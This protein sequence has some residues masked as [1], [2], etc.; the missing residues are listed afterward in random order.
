MRLQWIAVTAMAALLAGC[1]SVQQPVKQTPPPGLAK[2]ILGAVPAYEPL[3][4]VRI[5][6]TSVMVSSIRL[7]VIRKTSVS[8]AMPGFM[9][10]LRTATGLLPAKSST[11]PN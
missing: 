10:R 6:I 1:P 5:M 11:A 3:H 8:R 2:E 9:A 7:S 4:P